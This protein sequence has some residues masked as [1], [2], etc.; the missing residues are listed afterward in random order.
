MSDG[1]KDLRKLK[2]EELLDEMEYRYLKAMGRLAPIL[3]EYY[4]DFK[5]DVAITLEDRQGIIEKQ[6]AEVVLDIK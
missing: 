2:G 4:P 5:F 6:V 1:Q 3:Y